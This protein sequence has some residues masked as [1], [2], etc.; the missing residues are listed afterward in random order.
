VASAAASA[1]GRTLAFSA[2]LRDLLATLEAT[3]LLGAAEQRVRGLGEQLR[4]A[5]LAMPCAEALVALEVESLGRLRVPVVAD[6]NGW[7]AA[8]LELLPAGTPFAYL[9]SGGGGH[10]M[11]L[12]PD[13]EAV[14]ALRP[15]LA[16]APTS[17]IFVPIRFG[18]DAVGGAALLSH[19]APLGDREL[20]MA[21]RLAEVLALTVEAFRTERVLFELFARAL[22]DLLAPDAGTSLRVALE[23][24]VHALR[25]DPAYRRRLDLAVLVG[26]VADHGDAETAQA[27]RVLGEVDAYLRRLEGPLP[28]EGAGAS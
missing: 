12:A 23:Q 5:C 26:R 15:A 28:G 9:L 20:D 6:A 14:A 25:L 4:F 8:A 3:A 17:A 21:E 13:D 1:A 11:Q 19:G 18:G 7:R 24:Q 22:P 27:G 2:R 16:A 10:A